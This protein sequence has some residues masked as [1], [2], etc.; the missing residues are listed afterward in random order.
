MKKDKNIIILLFLIQNIIHN[1]GHPVTPAFVKSLGISDYMFGIFFATMS[2][3][4][5]LGGMIWG[6][7][8]DRGKKKTYI[9]LGLILYSIGQFGFGYCNNQ[10][11]MIIF[12]FISGFGVVASITLYTA[13]LVEITDKKE[14]AKYL[15]FISA[16]VT[17]GASIGYYLGGFIAEN[18][19]TQ[20]LF[21]ISNYKEIF[22]IQSLLNLLYIVFV[23]LVFKDNYS[24]SNTNSKKNI[25]ASFK[26]IR[27][28]DYRLLLFLIALIFISIGQINIDKYL[29]VYFD[30]LGYNSLSIGIFKMVIGLVSLIT[31]IF[32]VK[33][34]AKIRKQLG[35]MIVFLI[36]SSF[37]IFYTFRSTNFIVIIY[38]LFMV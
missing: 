2:F 1:M 7:L 38:S 3:G 25:L 12:R 24:D 15:A 9:V 10:Y 4:L 16:A 32:L 11:L 36:I 26:S 29:D 35:L 8:G 28:I 27:K 23:L 17:L 14:R 33:H 20:A 31:S 37:V 22:L 6:G 19:F 30:D 21:N 34:F 5:V 13:K 18:T